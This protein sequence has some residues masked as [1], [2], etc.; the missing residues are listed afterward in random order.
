V[1]VIGVPKELPHPHLGVGIPKGRKGCCELFLTIIL[2][3]C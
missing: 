2:E 3:M 1:G